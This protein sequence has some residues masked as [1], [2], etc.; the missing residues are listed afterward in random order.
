MGR[1]FKGRMDTIMK[2]GVERYINLNSD[3]LLG[4]ISNSIFSVSFLTSCN[5]GY[6]VNAIVLRDVTNINVWVE[7]VARM[8]FIGL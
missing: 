8:I 3:H 4:T 6:H 5:D 1:Y 2:E 7:A